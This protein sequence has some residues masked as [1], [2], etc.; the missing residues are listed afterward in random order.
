MISSGS[1]RNIQVWALQNAELQ[2]NKLPMQLIHHFLSISDYFT[3]THQFQSELSLALGRTCTANVS[4]KEGIPP[5]VACNNWSPVCP[6][7]I[8][9]PV[10]SRFLHP[11]VGQCLPKSVTNIQSITDNPGI[12]GIYQSYEHPDSTCNSHLAFLSQNNSYCQSEK[13]QIEREVV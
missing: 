7:G 1:A 11:F 10:S 13:M 9:H 8:I 12:S 4:A 5:E 3:L 2:T 6:V